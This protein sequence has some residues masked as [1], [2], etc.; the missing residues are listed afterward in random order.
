MKNE[1][2]K[3]RTVS[4]DREDR[5]RRILKAEAGWDGEYP[6][7]VSYF[8]GSKLKELEILSEF[9]L[10]HCSA[11]DQ[12]I[13]VETAI[14]ACILF[15]RGHD[16]VKDKRI[17]A[18]RVTFAKAKWPLRDDDWLQSYWKISSQVKCGHEFMVA[19]FN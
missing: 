13:W 8:G 17:L 12:C 10:L 15:L 3:M 16:L 11:D 1:F 2:K 7:P 14:S 18:K 19:F 6:I 5:A 9:D 4:D